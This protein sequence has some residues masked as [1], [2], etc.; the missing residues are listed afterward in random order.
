MG[1]NR[2]EG[3]ACKTTRTLWEEVFYEDSVQFTDYYFENKA[4][5]NIGYVIGH[6]PYDAM[7]FRTPYTLQIG[8]VQKEIS[9]IVGVATR[10]ECRHRGC[11]RELLIHSFR[12]M[13]QEK[14]PFTFLMPA[15]P[16]IY[17]PFDF[18]YIYERDVWELKEPGR[19]VS[20][21]ESLTFQE[22]ECELRAAELV[23]NDSK[24]YEI[25][26]KLDGLYS[27]SSLQRK[28]PEFPIME[29]LA[30]F[31][32][33]YLKKNYNIYVH[34]DTAYY[35]IQLKESEA[36]NGDIYVLFEQGEIKAFFLYAKEGE[37]IFIQE[38]IEEKE[39]MLD[40]LQE[41]EKKQPIIM[42]RIIHLEE[43]MKLVCSKEK[44]TVVIEIEDELIPEN[45]GVYKWEITPDG[46]SVTKICGKINGKNAKAE[47]KI[48]DIGRTI[49]GKEISTA[50]DIVPEV[51]MHIRDF[52]PWV[53]TG[54]FINEIV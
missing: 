51:S 4:T 45:A 22:K 16:A 52:A 34:R 39:G 41:V 8:E 17:E 15:N 32:N 18:K 2:I 13:Y 53:L 5:K 46:S 11:M 28:I 24:L 14:N 38:V 12:E 35:E 9:Y 10:K 54:G 49:A 31:A 42:A 44:K 1:I 6:A 43:M 25:N 30:E 26:T 19:V 20:I 7:M 37:E 47:A 48:S 29:N 40:F 21:L 23:E 27:V 36:Q 33:Q 50:P 3:E